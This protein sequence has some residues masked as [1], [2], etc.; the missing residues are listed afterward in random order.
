VDFPDFLYI[1]VDK[2]SAQYIYL[3]VNNDV[4]YSVD[5]VGLV[6]TPNGWQKKSIAWERDI[7]RWGLVRS[8][9]VP[10]D[11]VG[12]GATLARK[13][14]LQQTKEIEIELL[15]KILTLDVTGPSTHNWE[16]VDFYRGEIE[17]A[18]LESDEIKVTMPIVEGGIA[19]L[20]KANEGT[21][22]EIPFDEYKTVKMDGIYL[23]QKGNY[24]G[25]DGIEMKKSSPV[26]GANFFLPISFIN[27]DGTAPGIAFVSQELATTTT[28]T[29]DQI[30]LSD[31]Y[32][33]AASPSNVAS[34]NMIITGTLKFKCYD[35][36]PNLG[37][38]GRFLRSTQLIAN[39]NDYQ[40]F[41]IAVPVVGQEYSFDINITI[42]L[43][44]GEKLFFKAFTL[45]VLL[46]R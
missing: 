36:D 6:Y 9:T 29:F 18:Q 3:D 5:P 23:V 44:P 4:A 46:E 37:F 30:L 26:V 19:K 17:L 22:Y 15:I 7:K 1:L 12:D 32:L 33:I 13:I 40:V 27:S 11:F 28:L 14:P 35:N 2:L 34:V 42:P 38:R 24:F 16:Y 25:V 8:F 31:N 45:V 21:V 39:Q 20:L 10:L 41:S 43:A